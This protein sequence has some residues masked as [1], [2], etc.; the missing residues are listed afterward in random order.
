MGDIN[1]MQYIFLGDFCDRGLYSLEVILLLFA[2][3]AK[4]QSPIPI[5]YYHC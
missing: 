4:Y 2:L 3:K 1:V 5:L